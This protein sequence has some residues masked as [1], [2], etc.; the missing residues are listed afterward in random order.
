MNLLQL[1]AERCF[2]ICQKR[3]RNGAAGIRRC[4]SETCEALVEVVVEVVESCGVTAV[5]RDVVEMKSV[6]FGRIRCVHPAMPVG[7]FNGHCAD[8]TA[9]VLEVL[10]AIVKRDVVVGLRSYFIR[11]HGRREDLDRQAL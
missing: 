4:E 2:E 7:L 9:D 8:R 10:T 1:A 5:E 11:G 3:L 6:G